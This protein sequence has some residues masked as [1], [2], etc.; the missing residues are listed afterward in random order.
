MVIAHSERRTSV[1]IIERDVGFFVPFFYSRIG[2]ICRWGFRLFV[3]RLIHLRWTSRHENL[4]DVT[5][6]KHSTNK[7]SDFRVLH[8]R[9]VSTRHIFR[10][11]L[12]R[13]IGVVPMKII[14]HPQSFALLEV[15]HAQGQRSILLEMRE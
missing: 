2:T 15:P 7:S 14:I 3:I 13:R 10:K 8:L 9:F 11:D 1:L 5:V 12:K 6:T 4:C